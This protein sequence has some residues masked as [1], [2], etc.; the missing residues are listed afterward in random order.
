MEMRKKYEM[1]KGNV[2]SK[3]NKASSKF[4]KKEN[5]FKYQ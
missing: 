3:E 5:F 1:T 4:R 2:F